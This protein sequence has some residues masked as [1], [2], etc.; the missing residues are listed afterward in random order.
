MHPAHDDN[1][2][3]TNSGTDTTELATHGSACQLSHQRKKKQPNKPN[4][5]IAPNAQGG[6][7]YVYYHLNSIANLV[8]GLQMSLLT[9]GSE[10]NPQQ[11]PW[12]KLR[13]PQELAPPQ[14]LPFST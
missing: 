5:K 6:I 14:V 8:R 4:P 13:L 3:T 9:S 11:A 10:G 2:K 7:C 12:R 1:S